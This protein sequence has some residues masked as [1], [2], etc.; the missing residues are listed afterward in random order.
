MKGIL[1]ILSVL[2]SFLTNL[3]TKTLQS[4]FVVTVSE[5][6]NAPMNFPGSLTMHGQ[7]FRL[8][9]FN[10]QAAYDGDPAAS[11]KASNFR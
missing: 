2:T 9:M 3:E 7:L 10:I 1:V 8:E 11:S 4:D 5:E 6:V